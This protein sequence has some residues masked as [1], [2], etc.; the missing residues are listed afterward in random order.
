MPGRKIT[1]AQRD[2]ICER[3]QGGESTR[4]IAKALGLSKYGVQY[5]L[6]IRGV[7]L[8]HGKGLN[9][10]YTCDHAYFDTISDEARAYW[11][12][13]ILAD[14]CVSQTNSGSRI[15]TVMLQPRDEPH[16]VKLRTALQSTHPISQQT[17]NNTYIKRGEQRRVYPRLTITSG[18]IV[19]ALARCGVVRNKTQGHGTPA[20]APEL[21]R[22]FYRGFVDGDGGMGLY[23]N[24]R[25]GGVAF[26]CVGP[27]AFLATF[28]DWLTTHAGVP[29]K[30]PVAVSYT[31]VIQRLQ[32][33]GYT[34]VAAIL[35]TL[36]DDATAFLDR[37]ME[38]TQS[39]LQA[40][41]SARPFH[42]RAS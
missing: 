36:Y 2:E 27:Q 18:Q 28:A 22:H 14:G 1:D 41:Q 37:K 24:S 6:K 4:K 25:G 32:Y 29:A 34:Q 42:R 31:S 23:Q 30:Q 26:Y 38:T 10:R 12:G 40:A 35:H 33:G 17:I 13:F 39:I 11:L 16:L 5:T 8:R 19:D 15:L 20:L 3:Y 21:M 7:T 9:R